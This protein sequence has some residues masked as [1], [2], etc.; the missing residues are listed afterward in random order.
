V[1]ERIAAPSITRLAADAVRKMIFAGEL[2]PGDR[3]VEG[4]VAG[5]LGVSAPALRAAL[6]V[7]ERI[8]R[9]RAAY[10][11]L[12]QATE[13]GDEAGVIERGFAFHVAVVGLAG[14]GGLEDA[15]RSPALQLRLCRVT[16]RRV[17]SP[18]EPLTG[19]ARRHRRILEL[20][21]HGDGSFLLQADEM[22]P[23]GSPESPARP[24]HVRRNPG[25]TGEVCASSSA[26]TT[27]VSRSRSTS[28]PCS[29][30]WGTR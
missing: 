17:R 25:G 4:R 15:Y 7:L 6:R 2:R 13:A 8:T 5:P 9:C 12:E 11:A 26:T 27:P 23:G 28:G 29:K 20:A 21:H 3:V 18:H 24:D 16:N 14:H 19:D 1:S 30:G 22:F 10:A